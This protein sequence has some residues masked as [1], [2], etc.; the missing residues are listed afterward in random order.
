RPLARCAA[1][2]DRVST[3]VHPGVIR[4]Q[5]LKKILTSFGA[6]IRAVLAH[7]DVM[8]PAAAVG[9]HTGDF[10]VNVLVLL[11]HAGIVE[12]EIGRDIGSSRR[13]YRRRRSRGASED[14]AQVIPSAYFDNTGRKGDTHNA[15]ACR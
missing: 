6:A 14:T 10:A 2:I 5:N 7:A 4:L 11:Q 8:T 3:N 12:G 1:D 13:A 15:G 9:D